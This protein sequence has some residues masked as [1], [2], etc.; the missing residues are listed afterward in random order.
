MKTEDK[1]KNRKQFNNLLKKIS[2]GEKQALDDFYLAY[3]KMIYS[4]ALSISKSQD[5]ADEIVNDVLA[6]IWISAKTQTNIDKPI[7]WLNKVTKNCAID[8]IKR[9][10]QLYEIFDVLQ[11]DNNL[12]K[13][14]TDDAFYFYISR[15][16]EEEQQVFILRFVQRLT[17]IQI[18]KELKRPLSTVSSIYYRA[19]EKLRPFFK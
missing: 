18:A 4:I 5:L 1:I 3:G 12:E 17:F 8:R 10:E 16:N 6:K 15:L 9:E 13:L 7:G 19:L 2:Q 14:E 11:D